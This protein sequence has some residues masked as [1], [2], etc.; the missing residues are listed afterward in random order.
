M[1][2]TVIPDY[3]NEIR[4]LERTGNAGFILGFGLKLAR[5]QYLLNRYPP[6]WVA[7]YEDNGYY[8]GDPLVYWSVAV[9]GHRRWSD[10]KLDP[11]E[12]LPQAAK[13][14]LKYGA[15][16]STKVG[17]NRSFLSIARNDRELTDD[18]IDLLV[19]K[20]DLW[21]ALFDRT[22]VTLS[23]KEKQVLHLVRD[24]LSQAEVAETLDIH[25]NTV[26]SRLKSAQGKLGS[27]NVVSAIVKAT[28]LD[29]L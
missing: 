20:L 18:E 3:E 26:K 29:I 2:M 27:K 28:E 12:V 7:I 1:F 8:F 15:T 4:L 24:G 13:F 25:L 14:G 22:L 10:I 9:S 5:P 19:R 23:D 6:E 17:R 16:M 21:S 11:R